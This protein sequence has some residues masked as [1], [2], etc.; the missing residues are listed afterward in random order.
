ML[1]TVRE[2]H[3]HFF[4]PLLDGR[5][6]PCE[7][8]PRGDRSEED[9]LTWLVDDKF[10]ITADVLAVEEPSECAHIGLREILISDHIDRQTCHP[11]ALH[12]SISSTPVYTKSLTLRVAQLASCARQIAAICADV[13]AD[14]VA[15]IPLADP[16]PGAPAFR[17]FRNA[18]DCS[19][20]LADVLLRLTDVPS[21]LREVPDR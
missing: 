19:L 16:L 20:D 21:L 14:R 6:D 7:L 9:R 10:A 17:V 11:S 1:T 15:A 2:Q 4:S 3:L 13:A 12:G 18:L 5:R 8:E